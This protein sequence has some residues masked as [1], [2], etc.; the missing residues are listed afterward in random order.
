M[1]YARPIPWDIYEEHLDEA[2]FL[3]G[4]WERALDAANYTLDEVI[5][6]PEER[7]LAHLDG[8]VLGGTRVAEKLLVPALGDDDPGKV[9][10]ATWALLQAEDADHLERVFEALGATEKKETRLAMGRAFELCHR[11]D[12]TARLVPS[13]DASTPGVQ[14]VIVNA[15]SAEEGRAS[16]P[17]GYDPKGGLTP[18]LPL[19]TLLGTRN[20]ELLVAALR[21]LR[22]TRDAD[23]APLVDAPLGSPYVAVRDAAIETGVVLGMR[24][25]WRACNKLVARNAPGC[26]LPLALLALGGEPVD[27]KTVIKRLG[28]EE[29]RRDALW[30]L[31]FAGTVEAAEAALGLI[32]D[33][34]LGPLAGESFATITGAPMVGAMVKIGQTDNSSPPD[35][36]EDDDA[37]PPILRP[38]DD[39]PKPN[40]D[41]VRAWWEKAKAEE[42]KPGLQ[43]DYRYLYGQSLAGES[44]RSAIDTG[45]TWRRRVWSLESARRTGSTLQEGT[46]GRR[47]KGA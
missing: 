12:L 23:L 2:A 35:L 6:G 3:W 30:A 38:E 29:M 44:V 14:A 28:V 27:L 19:E 39:L 1:P 21:A 18:R 46:W 4:Q 17:R 41:R 31:G 8:L 20:P 40:G 37:P 47:Q 16:G 10:A 5:D 9:T 34:E 7:L 26:K 15:V 32:D 33:E 43:A 42:G 24:A 11:T 25:A 45:L 36:E 22:R 13:L